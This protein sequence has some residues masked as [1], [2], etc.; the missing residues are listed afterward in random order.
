MTEQE[1]IDLKKLMEQSHDLFS[2]IEVLRRKIAFLE[3][4]EDPSKNTCVYMNDERFWNTNP[5]ELKTWLL[6]DQKKQLNDVIVEL[7]QIK[8]PGQTKETC[9]DCFAILSHKYALNAKDYVCENCWKKRSVSCDECKIRFQIPQE[10]FSSNNMKLCGCC[11]GKKND[12]GCLLT[13]KTNPF[14]RFR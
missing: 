1:F 7:E 4:V 11:V 13:N 6:Q 8:L 3:Q 12:S 2:T 14:E 5:A 10:G 9:M